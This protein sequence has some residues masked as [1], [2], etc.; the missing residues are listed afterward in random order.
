MQTIHTH[1]K[2]PQT[3]HRAFSQVSIVIPDQTMSLKTMVTKYV[4]GLPIAAPNLNGTYTDDE[5]A[6][7]FKKLDLADQ[8]RLILR[9]SEELTNHKATIAQ[10]QAEQAAKQAADSENKDK[11]IADLK[12]KLALTP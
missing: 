5:D 11:E 1:Y 4:K 2:R 12:A 8:E 9:A 3:Q 7:D 6:I 10:Q